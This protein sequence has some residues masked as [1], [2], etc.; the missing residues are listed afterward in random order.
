MT[1]RL[2][3]RLSIGLAAGYAVLGTLEVVLKVADEAAA[4]TLVFFGG[5]LLGGAGLIA[6]GLGAHGSGTTRRVCVIAG[7]ATGFL[8]GAW[9]LVLPLLAVVV[10]VANARPA[11]PDPV[12]AGH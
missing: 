9:T 5:T 12:P 1:P 11:P 10:I 6:Y 3:R 2:V 4:A 7:A 8:A